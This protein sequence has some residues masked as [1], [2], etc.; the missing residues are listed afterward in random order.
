MILTHDFRDG[1]IVY[2]ATIVIFVDLNSFGNLAFYFDPLCDKFLP[3][4][5][6]RQHL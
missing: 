5:S 1:T 2:H 6:T 3:A 4:L